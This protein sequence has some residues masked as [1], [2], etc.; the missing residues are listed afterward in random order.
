[1]TNEIEFFK[2]VN[3]NQ[4]IVTSYSYNFFTLKVKN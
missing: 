2:G 3:K 4:K 1:M